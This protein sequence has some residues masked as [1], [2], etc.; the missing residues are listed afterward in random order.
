MFLLALLLDLKA[1]GIAARGVT[2]LPKPK[3]SGRVFPARFADVSASAGLL[4]PI[5]TGP[6]KP[7][8]IVEAMGTGVAF[9]D[10]DSDGWI[11]IFLANGTPAVGSMLY[12]NNR[13]GTFTDVSL[14]A[15]LKQTGWG[16]GVTVA[17]YD[18]DSFPDLYVTYWGHDVLYR[19]TG[20]G[21]FEDVTAKAGLARSETRWGSGAS[22]FDYDRDGDLDLFVASY[23]QFDLRTAPPPGKDSNCVWLGVPVFCG[24]R[25]LPFASNALYR[26]DGGR[27]VDVS[28]QSR[29]AQPQ[30]TYALGVLAAD[31]DGDGWPD[32][33]VASDSTRSLFYHN[34]TDGTF[35]ERATYT[36]LAYDENGL[37]QAGMGLA[38]GDYDGDGLLDIAK[39]N[40]AD[41]YPN[42]YRNLGSHGYADRALHAGLGVNPQYVLWSAIFA[43]FDNDTWP[44]LFFA[45]G[46]VFTEL[47]ARNPRLLYWNLGGGKFEDV[48]GAAGAGI[49][50]PHSS[51]GAAW[52]DFDNDGDAD[53][54]VMNRNEPPSL[55]RNHNTSGSNWLSIKLTGTK[56]N[57][58]AIGAVVRV[59]AGGRKMMDVV[60]SQSGYYSANDPRLHFGLGKAAKA[61]AVSV[62]WPTGQVETWRDV[63]A[64]QFL[65]LTEGS[66]K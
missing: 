58:S 33:Y 28:E 47:G 52:G 15:G 19:N 39:T 50:A 11:D 21:A 63:A 2:A 51:R 43:D 7:S 55:L 16:Q 14:R 17:D 18:N 62:T 65:A 5:S 37:E 36:G 22:F 10:F 1:Q 26:N 12:R 61:D 25:G 60:L 8:Y 44:D 54:L 66:A 42:L 9:L 38:L 32:V 35:T 46:H 30:K 53:L 20:A 48:S 64:N 4:R 34:N 41:D 59:E 24:P 49:S 23:L 27:F 56:S 31:M 6:A 3:P 13:N 57:R 45:A 40:F 29:I